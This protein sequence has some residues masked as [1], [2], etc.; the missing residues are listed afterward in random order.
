M[1]EQLAS[2]LCLGEPIQL[3]Q[4]YIEWPFTLYGNVSSINALWWQTLHGEL[5]PIWQY[6]PTSAQGRLLIAQDIAWQN[7]WSG[8]CLPVV[9]AQPP[10]AYHP[11]IHYILTPETAIGCALYLARQCRHQTIKPLLLSEHAGHLPVA[12]QPSYIVVDGVPA[13]VTAAVIL[14]EDWQIPSRLNCQDFRPGCFQGQLDELMAYCRVRRCLEK[15]HIV[16]FNEQALMSSCFLEHDQVSY[17]P[18]AQLSHVKEGLKSE[19]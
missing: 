16:S 10:Y 6:S 14:L 17:Y 15:R 1:S 8:Q 3:N 11:S 18:V 7:K 13:G 9:P 5:L 12:Y 2:Q 19:V 4:R